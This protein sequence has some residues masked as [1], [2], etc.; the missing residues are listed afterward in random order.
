MSGLASR[1]FVGSALTLAAGV[2]A[3]Q[4]FSVPVGKWWERPRV[5]SRL[6]IT[7]DQVGKLNAAT[8]PHAKAMVDLKAAVDKATIDLQAASDTEPFDAGRARTA[9]SALLQAREKLELERFE[10]LLKVK[11]ILTPDQWRQLQEL[12]RERRDEIKEGAQATPGAG[13]RRNQPNRWPE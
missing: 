3:A 1:W 11:A 6:G 4:P 10:M 12:L 7:Q 2:A 5:A 8:Y 9:F 13:P